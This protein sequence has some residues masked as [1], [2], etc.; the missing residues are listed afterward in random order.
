MTI[1]PAQ[2]GM[3]SSD[4]TRL[5]RAFAIA[6]A[7]PGTHIDLRSKQFWKLTKTIRVKPVVSDRVTFSIEGSTL[8]NQIIGPDGYAFE[9]TEAKGCSF[10]NINIQGHSGLCF[11]ATHSSSLNTLRGCSFVG[12]HAAGTGFAFI[13]QGGADISRIHLDNCNV[14]GTDT[15]FL[16]EGSNNLDP[17]LLNCCATNC[18][19][20]LDLRQGGCNAVAHGFKGSC[21]DELIVCNGGYQARFYDIVSE[22][23]QVCV[24]IGGDDAGGSAQDQYHFVSFSDVRS[25]MPFTLL[26]LNKAGNT[27]VDPANLRG[28]VKLNNQGQTVGRLK[29]VTGSCDYQKVGKW[30]IMDAVSIN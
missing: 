21:T 12:T 22:F 24:R 9:F 28:L 26:E 19:T 29:V 25:D 13:A 11:N 10:T 16:F 20:G 8:W 23:P 14:D 6:A 2:S 4:Q 18:L 1:D 15:G 7:N 17:F 3:G 27:V 5:E 30:E